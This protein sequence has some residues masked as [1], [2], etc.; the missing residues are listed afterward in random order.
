MPIKRGNKV[1]F[2]KLSGMD[3][4]FTSPLSHGPE[5]SPSPDTRQRSAAALKI[6]FALLKLSVAIFEFI[7]TF[8]SIRL[9][10]VASFYGNFLTKPAIDRYIDS[11]PLEWNVDVNLDIEDNQ[12]EDV[13]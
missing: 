2:C 1:L 9:R 8:Y 13:P 5:G 11:I 3:P 12:A 10:V 4:A 6:L 7:Q